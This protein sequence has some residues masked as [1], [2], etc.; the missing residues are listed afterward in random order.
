MKKVRA[1][2]SFRLIDLILNITLDV[3]QTNNYKSH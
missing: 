2:N 3:L 1:T